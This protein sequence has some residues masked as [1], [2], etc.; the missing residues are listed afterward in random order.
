MLESIYHTILLFALISLVSGTLFT[1]KVPLKLR[2]LMITPVI[3]V[4]FFFYRGYKTI[5]GNSI[6]LVNNYK[7]V[8]VLGYFPDS[9]NKI[10][11]MWLRITP[12]D[13]PKSF[14]IPYSPQLHRSLENARKKFQGKPYYANIHGNTQMYKRYDRH[15][16]QFILIPDADHNTKT[17]NILNPSLP[18]KHPD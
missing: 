13:E 12:Q 9:K 10:I 1:M 7:K 16:N 6:L 15:R 11:Y 14:K 5:H 3:L 4:G 18:P 8:L 2:L 17:M